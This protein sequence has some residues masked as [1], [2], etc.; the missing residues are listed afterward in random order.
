VFT[1]EFVDR[2]QGAHLAIN[3]SGYNTCTNVLEA[4]IRAILIP[5]PRASDQPFRAQRLAER[6]VGRVLR[7]DE[8][9]A[10]RLAGEIVDALAGPAPEHDFDLRGAEATLKITEQL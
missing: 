6:G 10:E 1:P 9:T 5:N 2:L 7:L 3:Q 8:A 4:R